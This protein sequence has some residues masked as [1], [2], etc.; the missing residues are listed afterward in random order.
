PDLFYYEVVECRRR[1][2]LTG[3][4]IFIAPHT[5]TQVAMACIFAFASILGF[6]LMGPHM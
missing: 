5:A 1:M 3:V 6:E 2:L 4:L